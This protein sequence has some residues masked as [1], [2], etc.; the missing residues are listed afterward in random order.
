MTNEHLTL[1]SAT[2]PNYE[3]VLL[4]SIDCR[5]EDGETISQPSAFISRHGCLLIEDDEVAL[6]AVEAIGRTFAEIGEPEALEQVRASTAPT[7]T[8]E[9]FVLAN[10]TDPVLAQSRSAQLARRPLSPP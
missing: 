7:E 3:A 1:I 4:E 6:S 2:E 5:L 10:V 9:E 8:I